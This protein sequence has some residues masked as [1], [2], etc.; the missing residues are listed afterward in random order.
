MAREPLTMDMKM[1]GEHFEM[2]ASSRQQG[3]FQF[4]WTLQP[5]KKGPPEHFHRHER[6]SFEVEEGEISIWIGQQLHVL[7]AGDTASVAPMVPHRFLNHGPVPVVVRVSL[8]GPVLED[9]LV[10]MALHLR[11]AGRFGA[12]EVCRMIVHDGEYRGSESTS[13]FVERVLTPALVWVLRR[14]GVR[15]FDVDPH[16]YRDQ[17]PGELPG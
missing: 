17:T 3:L 12:A 7:R 9:S 2:L 16:W 15:P 10:P 5:G 8:D 13:G 4:R 6:E 11:R 14:L 1:T